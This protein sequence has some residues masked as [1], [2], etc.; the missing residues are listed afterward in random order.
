MNSN[1]IKCVSMPPPTGGENLIIMCG[2]SCLLGVSVLRALTATV[3]PFLPTPP[4]NIIL[5]VLIKDQTPNGRASNV[6]IPPNG[7]PKISCSSQ[8]ERRT[9][10]ID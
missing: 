5:K 6:G 3:D 10:E 8:S 2:K 4:V 7:T 9:G 1:Q